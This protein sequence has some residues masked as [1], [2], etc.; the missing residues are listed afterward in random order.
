[1]TEKWCSVVVLIIDGMSFEGV[2]KFYAGATTKSKAG[3]HATG[4]TGMVR[5][6]I[7]IY[8]TEVAPTM[9][10]PAEVDRPLAVVNDANTVSPT[11]WYV[12]VDHLNRSKNLTCRPD[13]AHSTSKWSVGT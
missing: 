4:S 11:V 2:K 1:M 8:E 5:E 10:S 9:A 13:H 3:A 7:W 6:Y 12:H